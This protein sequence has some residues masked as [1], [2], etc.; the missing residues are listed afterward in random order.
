M[1]VTDRWFSD[2]LQQDITVARWGTYGSP[3]L[4]FP[5]A[6][7]D[8]EEVERHKMIA[9]LHPLIDAGRAKVYSVDSVAGKALAEGRG[10]VDYQLALFNRFHETI[11]REVIPAIHSDL[12]GAP[13]PVVVAGASIGA[14]N[15]LAITCRY[16]ELVGAAVCMSGTYA[17]EKFLGGYANDDLYFSSPLRFLPGLEGPT[18]D[19]LRRRMVVLAS[20]SGQWEDV[21]ESWA[22]A[23]VLGEKGIPNRVDDWG[24]GYKHDWPTWWEMLPIYLDDLL[25]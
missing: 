16:P 10:S 12:G 8:A 18:L 13:I 22:A 19:L 5:T 4:L 20:G 2:R 6:G 21:G 25:P 9:H 11:A 7:G 24:P 14:F 1:K 15:A 23:K 17:I 3:V